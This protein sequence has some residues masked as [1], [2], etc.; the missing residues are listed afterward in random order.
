MFVKPPMQ[1]HKTIDSCRSMRAFPVSHCNHVGYSSRVQ[2]SPD[3]K[4]RSSDSVEGV[5][6]R[7]YGYSKCTL[8]V[9][10]GKRDLELSMD[11]TEVELAA[12]SRPSATTPQG[13][14]YILFMW[15]DVPSSICGHLGGGMRG[16]A[17]IATAAL[18]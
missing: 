4:Q 13:A 18:S 9:A 11:P 12:D 3:I 5:T 17:M 6:V 16:V 10:S 15:Y 14:H 8:A 1:I 2:Q 7:R